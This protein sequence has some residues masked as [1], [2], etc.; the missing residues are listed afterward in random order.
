MIASVG[1]WIRG[2]GTS[3]TETVC[4]D[5][6]VSARMGPIV[7]PGAGRGEAWRRVRPAGTCRGRTRGPGQAVVAF[8]AASLVASVATSVEA[9]AASSVEAVP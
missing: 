4:L 6:Q 9:F 2:S 8:T 1:S 7:V 5:C 3:S